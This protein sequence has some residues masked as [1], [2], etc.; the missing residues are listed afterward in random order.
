MQ[1]S[2]RD[3][4][5]PFD[6]ASRDETVVETPQRPLSPAQDSSSD[7]KKEKSADVA[8]TNVESADSISQPSASQPNDAVQPIKVYSQLRKYSLLAVFCLAQFLD[9]FNLSAAFAAIPTIAK[10]LN[11]NGS[12]SVWI[13]SALQ[14]T[15]SAFLLV[16]SIFR[17]FILVIFDN[18]TLE[19]S[20]KRCV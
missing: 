8:V 15:F 14:L 10:D 19:R 5:R 13:I 17:R 9:I 6:A 20:H 3:S 12:E 18:A 1:D 7:E 16:V 4:T 11:M 2:S